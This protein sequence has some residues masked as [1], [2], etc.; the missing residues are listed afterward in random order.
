[1]SG[2]NFPKAQKL[3]SK[4]VTEQLFSEGRSVFLFPF[5]IAF[6][7]RTNNEQELPQVLISV[8]KRRFKHAV[9]RNLLKRRIREAYR[10]IREEQ[11][12]KLV[13]LQAIAF[14]YV[15]KEKIPFETIKRKMQKGLSR[16]ETAASMEQ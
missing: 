6:L 5:K 3:C 12:D 14:I 4:K 16:I 9:D 2:Q 10:L 11:K 15:A 13:G 7:E 8:S 1:M